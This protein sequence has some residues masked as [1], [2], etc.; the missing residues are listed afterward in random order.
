MARILLVD[1]DPAILRLLEVN[2]RLEG[3]E[4]TTA[5]RGEDAIAA[6]S[7]WRP[8]AIVL[9][10]MLPGLDG[11]EV[12][13]RLQ[14]DDELAA[15]PVVFL[16]ARSAEDDVLSLRGTDATFVTKPFDPAALVET[17]RDRIEEAS[18]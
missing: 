12:Y 15:V 6:A 9:D 14:D 17:V 2:F 4:T 10:L 8:D 3:F 11:A 1:D 7:T 18:R 13:R 16:S 5:S